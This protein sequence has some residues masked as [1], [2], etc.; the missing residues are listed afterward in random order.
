MG[1]PK[2]TLPLPDRDTFLSRI[3]R[4]FLTAGIG[5]IVVV[6]G[7]DAD[8]VVGSCAAIDDVASRVRFVENPRYEDGQLS[9]L[10]AGIAAVD[11]PGVRASLVTL[12]D[13]PLFAPSTVRAVVECFETEMVPG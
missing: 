3:V 5:D 2:A 8:R 11:R 1:R 9:S 12:V 13:V 7:H 10:L 4:T 6:V